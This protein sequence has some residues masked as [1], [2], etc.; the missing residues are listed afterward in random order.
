[1]KKKK[2]KSC[3]YCKGEMEIYK[4]SYMTS[5]DDSIYPRC[6]KCGTV[7]PRLLPKIIEGFI[8]E[9]YYEIWEEK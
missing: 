7:F 4:L 3:P 6:K 2:L 8:Y 5:Y 1:M 9:K